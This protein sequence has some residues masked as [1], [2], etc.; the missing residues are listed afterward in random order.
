MRR[1][2]LLAALA[3][4]GSPALAYA[5]EGGDKKK[6]GGL[7]YIPIDTLTGATNKPDGRRGVLSVEC[8]LDVP[9]DAL[10][11]RAQASVPRLR[12]AYVQT[13]MIYAAGLPPDTAPDTDYLSTTL[14]RATNRVLGRPGARLLLGAVLVN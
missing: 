11:A 6:S 3:L 5:G 14:Q 12:A 13:V 2:E 8:G 1:R 9:D 7:S 10:R 4:A